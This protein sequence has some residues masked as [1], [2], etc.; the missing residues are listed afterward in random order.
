MGKIGNIQ[1]KSISPVISA[2][3]ACYRVD[4][5]D[6]TNKYKISKDETIPVLQTFHTQGKAL[7]DD[8]RY[9]VVKSEVGPL[10]KWGL[11]SEKI[12]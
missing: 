7:S 8:F 3:L 9:S 2:L 12:N 4:W 10:L 11:F 1:L 5:S 6:F